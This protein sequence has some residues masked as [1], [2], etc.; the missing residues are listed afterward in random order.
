VAVE[1]MLVSQPLVDVLGAP[2]DPL[3]QLVVM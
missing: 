3:G 2:L 1:H